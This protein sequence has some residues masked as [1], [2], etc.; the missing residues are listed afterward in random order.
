MQ[1][2]TLSDT[3]RQRLLHP[4]GNLLQ[5]FFP[6]ICLNSRGVIA[7]EVQVPFEVEFSRLADCFTLS[8]QEQQS[9]LQAVFLR[10]E[11]LDKTKSGE[12][13]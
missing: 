12:T 9:I 13:Q 11:Q 6:L 1:T 7:V 2:K 5:P 8:A 3:C 4:L 10:M